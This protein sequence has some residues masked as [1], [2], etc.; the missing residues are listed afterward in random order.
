MAEGS[1]PAP[2]R[3]TAVVV[4]IDCIT[5]L[6]TTRLLAAR[7]IPVVGIAADRGHFCARTRHAER[8]IASPT[9]G[10]GLIVTL[11]RLA[12]GMR[13]AVGQFSEMTDEIEA[14]VR[15][16]YSAGDAASVQTLGPVVNK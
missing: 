10:E 8:V 7:G 3:P 13:V 12:T 1:S 6:Q 9:S 16:L 4:A 15:H 5:G 2:R 14:R 11:E